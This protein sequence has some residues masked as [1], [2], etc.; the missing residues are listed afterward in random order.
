[1]PAGAN[2]ILD[3]GRIVVGDGTDLRDAAVAVGEG[4]IVSVGPSASVR[5]AFPQAEV[6]SYPRHLLMPGLV[7]AHTHL[8]MTLLRGYAEGLDLQGF[9]GR[10][11]PA[12]GEMMDAATVAL[13]TELGAA[14]SLRAGAT[15]ALD[16]Y[17]HPA[18]SHEAAVS[19]GLRHVT[20]PIFL[21]A[22]VVDGLA[23][24]QRLEVAGAWPDELARIGGPFVPAALLPHGTYTVS[25]EHLSEVADA[26]EAINALISVHASENIAENQGV[27][28]QY[29]ATPIDLLERAGVLARPTVIGH[30]VHLSDSDIAILARRGAAVAH[31]PVSNFKL[32]SGMADVRRLL[33]AGVAVAFGTD[34]CSSS[35]DL[36]PWVAM[37]TAALVATGV[38]GS[39]AT[40]L[41]PDIVS[42]ATLGGAAAL[43]L[44]DRIGAVREGLEADLI[45]LDL[46]QPHLTPIHDIHALL[47]FAA[48][49]GDVTDVFVAGEQVVADRRLTRVDVADLLALV[50]ARVDEHAA[51]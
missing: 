11:V 44:A 9:L 2:L 21:D 25:P 19:V 34:G 51:N 6:R 5:A 16:M 15:T 12:E 32:A 43:G 17:F 45:L 48:G 47:V 7:N 50:R 23:W 31:C 3:V 24:E 26:A 4:R 37:R 38:T 8:A 35:N 29:G 40:L 33:D 1:M 10:V 18:A 20:G 49:K 30:G 36:D 42:M 13:G 27:A 41:A 46:D 39:P 22:P 14:E 28:A